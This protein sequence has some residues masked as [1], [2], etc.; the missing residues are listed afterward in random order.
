[1]NKILSYI[2]LVTLS[3]LSIAAIDKISCD[4]SALK[5][6]LSPNLQPNY[7]YDSAKT[8][9]FEYSSQSHGREI[10]VP[11]Y[12]G[13]KYIFLFNTSGLPEAIK[14]EIYSERIGHK[15]RE[16][17]YSLEHE[18]GK[19]IYSF[20]PTTSRKMY[21]NYTIPSVKKEM[22]GCMVFMLGYR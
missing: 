11:L 22:N 19:N 4:E 12:R 2:L 3:V 15:N 20:E 21:V 14:I 18:E 7:K 17:L 8:S 13:E 10:L 16:L 9:Q 6:E 1:M 5:K